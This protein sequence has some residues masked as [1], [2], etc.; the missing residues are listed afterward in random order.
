MKVEVAK[1]CIKSV[2]GSLREEAL[3]AVLIRTGWWY[4][5]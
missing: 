3:G 1:V 2:D 5:I 4:K